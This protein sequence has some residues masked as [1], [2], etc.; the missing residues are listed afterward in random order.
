MSNKPYHR[1]SS[2][3]TDERRARHS[4]AIRAWSPWQNSTGPR[5]AE[6]KSISRCNA[7]KHGATSRPAKDFMRH[8]QAYRLFLRTC[9]QHRAALAEKLVNQQNELLNMKNYSPL[10]SSSSPLPAGEG[11]EGLGQKPLAGAG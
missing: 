9:W 10:K 11:C 5:T 3:W 6:G 1:T 8:F 2:G 7:L 4:A